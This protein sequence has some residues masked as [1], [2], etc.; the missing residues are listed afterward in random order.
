MSTTKTEREYFLDSI[1]ACLMLLGV[2]FHVSLIYSSQ[3]WAVNSSDAS[4]WLTTLNDFIHAFR[5]QVFFVISGYFSYMLYLRYQ[6]RRFL[7][8]RLERVGI[9]MLTAVPL[10]TLPQFFMLKAWTSKYADWSA[11]PPYAKF[12]NLMWE[13]ISHLWFL[14]VLLIL[15]TL[16]MITFRWLRD[17]KRNIDYQ[18]VGWG[19]LAL[20]LLIWGLM[21]GAFRRVVF[22]TNPTLLS[23]ALF[24]FVVMQS[25]FYLPFFMLGA[26]SWKHQA[27]KQLFVRVNP[28]LFIGAVLLL[29][30]YI[31]NQRTSSG[32]GWLYE[33][34]ALISSMMGLCML[35]VC[36]SLGHKL[37]NSHSPGIMYLVNASL[38]IYLVHHPLT[39]LYGIYVTPVLHNNTLGFLLGLVMVFGVSFT[40]YELHLRIPLL[41]FLFSGKPQKR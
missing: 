22:Y 4:L 20:S 35:N 13:L 18:R 3:K 36:Y 14:L 1:R 11:L 10:I 32:E 33:L 37:L 21:W 9:P 28:V 16:G 25:L 27:L 12:N 30:A 6:P 2:P 19:K 15:T 34:D 5:M 24:N 23:D 17:Q 41:R 7:K 40:L 29:V 26:L 38:F 39:L 8:V 31:V